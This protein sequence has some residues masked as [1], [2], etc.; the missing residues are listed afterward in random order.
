MTINA[1]DELIEKLN[2]IG[3]SLDDIKAISI[4]LNNFNREKN[5][6]LEYIKIDDVN[7]LKEIQYYDGFGIQELFGYVVFNDNTWLEREAYEG[8]EWWEYRSIYKI[9]EKIGEEM[10]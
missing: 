8:S 1:Y 3:K 4:R 9:L 7:D 5:Y 2:E 6:E 10:K